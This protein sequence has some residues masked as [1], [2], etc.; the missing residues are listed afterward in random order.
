MAASD[1]REVVI[2][3]TP[4]E[5]IDVIADVIADFVLRQGNGCFICSMFR[6]RVSGRRAGELRASQIARA[7]TRLGDLPVV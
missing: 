3:A 2:E 7:N 5:I 1:S 4:K 6:V